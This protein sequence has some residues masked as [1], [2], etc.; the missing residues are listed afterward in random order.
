[1]VK[2]K[3]SNYDSLKTDAI[4]RYGNEYIKNISEMFNEM[5]EDINRTKLKSQDETE[6]KNENQKNKQSNDQ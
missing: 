5:G 2:G 1:M 6:V 3:A 4:I